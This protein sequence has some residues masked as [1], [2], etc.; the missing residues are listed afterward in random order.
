MTRQRLFEI[1]QAFGL[2]CATERVT[3][4]AVNGEAFREFEFTG[5]LPEHCAD[6]AKLVRKEWGVTRDFC[7]ARMSD[8]D[9]KAY[10]HVSSFYCGPNA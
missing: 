4:G 8:D 6:M 5:N 10:V 9:Y 3:T 1:A 7:A 2:T